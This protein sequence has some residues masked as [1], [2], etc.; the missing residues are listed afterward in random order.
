MIDWLINQ[1]K[2]KTDGGQKA[3]HVILQDMGIKLCFWWCT[4]CLGVSLSTS[5]WCKRVFFLPRSR[6]WNVCKTPK[7]E[8]STETTVQSWVRITTMFVC[9][10][11]CVQGLG[12]AIEYHTISWYVLSRCALFSNNLNYKLPGSSW[13]DD[14]ILSLFFKITMLITYIIQ[15]KDKA[16]LQF[17]SKLVARD[18]IMYRRNALKNR[19][20]IFFISFHP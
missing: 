13:F 17:V 15:L 12:D 20:M 8:L 4:F 16:C 2:T 18:H 1:K 19:D 14:K 7:E 6:T 10:W 11:V 3:F 9:G 5:S